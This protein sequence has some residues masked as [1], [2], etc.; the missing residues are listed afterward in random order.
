[1]LLKVAYVQKN[2]YFHDDKKILDPNKF[3]SLNGRQAFT[4]IACF[5]LQI[6]YVHVFIEI[7]F[8]MLDGNEILLNALFKKKHCKKRM[9]TFKEEQTYAFYL[10]QD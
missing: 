2:L 9:I 1:M 10:L 8:P 5:Y 4:E 3:P 7:P 6:F